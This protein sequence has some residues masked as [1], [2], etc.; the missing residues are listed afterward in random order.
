MSFSTPGSEPVEVRLEGRVLVLTAL[1]IAQ[2]AGSIAFTSLPP[3]LPHYVALLHLGV[4]GAGLLSAGFGL[5]VLLGVPPACV[6]AGRNPRSTAMAGLLILAASTAI[7]GLARATPEVDLARPGAGSRR[8]L[9][10]HGCADRHFPDH[11]WRQKL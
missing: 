1:A 6:L 8:L 5:G 9:G 3:L 10:W 11:P 2:G 4:R 7:I